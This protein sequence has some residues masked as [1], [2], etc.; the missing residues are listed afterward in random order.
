MPHIQLDQLASPA[1]ETKLAS[2]IF[3]IDGLTQKPTRMSL[4][5]ARG[6][7]LKSKSDAKLSLVLSS[8]GEIGH[9]HPAPELGSMHLQIAE[10]LANELIDNEWG[11][12]HPLVHQGAFPPTLVMIYSPRNDEEISMLNWFVKASQAF[13]KGSTIQPYANI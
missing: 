3:S 2:S 10:D 9:I 7:F 8:D 11:E 12:F 5:G 13:V 1:I 4:P 6:I